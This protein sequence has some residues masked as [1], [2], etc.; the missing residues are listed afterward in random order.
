MGDF[1]KA[2]FIFILPLEI[3]LKLK[4]SLSLLDKFTALPIYVLAFSL[5]TQR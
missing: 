5:L 1:N 2:L 3:W 4:Y